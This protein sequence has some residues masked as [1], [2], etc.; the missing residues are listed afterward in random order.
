M[1]L[2]RLLTGAG[3]T[4]E[5]KPGEPMGR[6]TS[7]RI[8]GPAELMVFPESVE[9]LARLLALANGNGVPLFLLGRGTN[10]LVLDGGIPGIVVNLTKL[11][12][13]ELERGESNTSKVHAGAGAS[14]AKL[15]SHCAEQGLSGLE[16]TAGIP[17]TV[18]GAV[19]MNAGTQ[20]AEIKDVLT[21]VTL[22][23]SKGAITKMDAKELKMGYRHAE[24]PQGSA[25]AEASFAL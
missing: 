18:G 3:I 15:A 9:E 23:D 22:V 17:G 13:M 8:G 24:L 14:L 20:E 10:L 5:A 1:S 2:E 25:V 11:N 19:A 21:S 16:F 7:L 4:C 6:H 12:W